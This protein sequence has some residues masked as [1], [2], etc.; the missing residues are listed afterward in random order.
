M[1]KSLKKGIVKKVISGDTFIVLGPV[2]E[3]GYPMEKRLTLYGV[4][5]P[6][7][8]NETTPEDPFY[9]DAKEYLRERLAN[10]EVEFASFKPTEKAG[11]KP[12]G[13]MVLAHVY[14]NGEDIGLEMLRKGYAFISKKRTELDPAKSPKDF[15]RYKP[16]L[17]AAKEEKLGMHGELPKK[18]YVILKTK[19]QLA[20]EFA[21]QTLKGHLADITY[22]LRFEVF[23]N[24]IRNTITAE[25][26]GLYIPTFGADYIKK[27]R[28]LLYKRAFN[29]TLHFRPVSVGA[30]DIF[31]IEERD[32]S[33]SLAYLLLTTGYAKIADGADKHV[34]AEVLAKY[35]TWEAEA[36]TEGK[37]MWGSSSS[38]AGAK[39][40]A[41]KGSFIQEVHSGDS[42]TIRGKDGQLTRVFLSNIRA[43][44][45]GNPSKDD[46]GQP[47]GFEAREFLRKFVGQ[48]CSVSLD[49]IKKTVKKDENDLPV[50]GVSLQCATVIVDGLHLN[51]ELVARGL[52]KFMSPKDEK[53]RGPNLLELKEAEDKAIAE[54]VGLHSE[55][56]PSVR[57]YWDLSVPAVK[58]KAKEEYGT[59]FEKGTQYDGV[60]EH[61]LGPHRYKIRVDS[62][63]LYIVFNINGVRS[64]AADPNTPATVQAVDA[65]LAAV[66]AE[67][68]QRNVKFEV[69]NIDKPGNFHG[70][71]HLQSKSLGP[72]YLERGFLYISTGGRVVKGL[73]GLELAQ[74]KAKSTKRGVWQ[75]ENLLSV[76][77]EQ[78][79]AA[80]KAVQE[81][82][83]KC[84]LSE[85][86]GCDEF[87]VQREDGKLEDI[88]IIINESAD[89]LKQMKEPVTIGSLCLAKFDG[90]LYR[91]KVVRKSGDKYKIFFIDFG[92]SDLIEL[93]DLRTIPPKLISFKPEAI[94][95]CLAW[96]QAADDND[97]LMDEATEFF[98]SKAWEKKITAEV[99]YV[100]DHVSHVLI[101]PVSKNTDKDSINYLLLKKGL[102]RINPKTKLPTGIEGYWRD[103]E[104]EGIELNPDI[105]NAFK[106]VEITDIY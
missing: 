101:N 34:K 4:A 89:S 10:K 46:S 57:R 75:F 36:K 62:E 78:E 16:A 32:D 72:E 100:L 65:H 35:A 42:L 60:V 41:S 31:V 61:V 17:D 82:P 23:V 45:F 22:E 11:E 47:W 106:E 66:R 84:V 53:E 85:V 102:A 105:E 37:G 20:T 18:D 67:L 9:F 30:K 12:A 39:P 3:N 29:Q 25:L 83:F 64:L 54:K 8:G 63:K 27:L 98:K 51:V 50:E 86:I 73:E 68:L 14:L 44:N 15:S 21:G 91:G 49:F 38:A 90:G 33:K 74:A 28:I 70:V 88:H 7:K 43:P 104:T 58:K 71:I 40:A 24:K 87:Y 59:R 80:P 79:D 96:V 26:N 19:A 76:D 48:E 95:C 99:K 94:K 103:A 1:S 92:N 6:W 13:D 77:E 69:D 52:A 55:K 5:A 93:K 81:A 97:E 2:G 56:Q